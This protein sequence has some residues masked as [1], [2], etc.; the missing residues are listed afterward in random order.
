[1][2]FTSKSTIV[3]DVLAPLYGVAAPPPGQWLK[4][5]TPKQDRAGFL[6]SGAFLARASHAVTTSPTRRG[7]FIKERVLCEPVP[8]P[9]AGVNITL[10]DPKPGEAPK[11][12]K[13]I[14]EAH[15]KEERCKNCHSQFD[16][17]GFAFEHFDAIGRYRTVDAG[18]KVDS[19]G[20]IVGFGSFT[21]A[22]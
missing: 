17:Y 5:T 9:A 12:M 19:S 13:Q 10:Q 7:T 2:I 11:T 8:P 4:V 16:P 15:L 21:D 18:Q 22:R 6:T 14:M 1:E 3:D 20:T